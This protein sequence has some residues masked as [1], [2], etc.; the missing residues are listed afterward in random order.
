[1]KTPP[2]SLQMILDYKRN[3]QMFV[4]VCRVNGIE[5]VLMSQ[6]NNF[7]ILDYD[8][9]NNH[10]K[11]N[12][13]ELGED[14]RTFF[15]RFTGM[16]VAFNKAVEEVAVRNQ[17]LFVDLNSRIND[18]ALFQDEVHYNDRGCDTAAAII[19]ATVLP[20]LQGNLSK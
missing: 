8:W 7:D 11:I 9:F 6:A 17:C 1:M 10:N 3:L 19:A 20:H 12:F 2:D 13:Q 16:L 18:I 4:D 14:K 15:L 5:P